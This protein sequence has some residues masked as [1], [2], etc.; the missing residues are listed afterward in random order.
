MRR[1]RVRREYDTANRIVFQRNAIPGP[2]YYN[3]TIVVNVP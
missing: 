1:K 2:S 3:I